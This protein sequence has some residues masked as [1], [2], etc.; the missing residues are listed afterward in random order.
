MRGMITL[1]GSESKGLGEHRKH[2]KKGK[3]GKMRRE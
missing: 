3:T 2:N 1:S